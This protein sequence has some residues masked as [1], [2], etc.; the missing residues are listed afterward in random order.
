MTLGVLEFRDNAFIRAVVER[1]R[2]VPAEYV[3]LGGVVRPSRPPYRVVI[4]R[5]SFCDPFLRAVMRS[6]SLQGTYVMN[7]PYFTEVFDKLA[8]IAL[9]DALHIRHART[10]LLPRLNRLEDLREMVAEPDWNAVGSTVGFPCI[11]KPVDGYAWQEVFRVETPAML[12]GLY[13]TFRDSRTLLVQ[14]LVPYTAYYR[15][16]CVDRREVFVAGWKPAPFDQ[17][18]YFIPD[19]G[20]LRAVVDAV[21]DQTARLNQALG[22]DFNS[23]EWCVG[24]DGVPVVID[25][26]NDVPDVRPEK[27]PPTCWDWVVERFSA[28]VRARI[29]TGGRNGLAPPLPLDPGPGP[30]G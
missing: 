21:T 20:A 23:V 24:A 30:G 18:E 16:F 3:R 11:L 15:A 2:D 22:L 7:D 12:R 5:V 8:E 25:S 4:D 28:C 10:V 26:Y 19:P 27:L 13:E 1:L 29:A 9:Y 17:G 14:E 6:W